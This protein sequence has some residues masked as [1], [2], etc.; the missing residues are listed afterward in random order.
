MAISIAQKILLVETLIQKYESRRQEFRERKQQKKE[1]FPLGETD[2]EAKYKAEGEF[3]NHL[4]VIA[5]K[6]IEEIKEIIS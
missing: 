3:L 4:R 2:W 1:N 6:C 5:E